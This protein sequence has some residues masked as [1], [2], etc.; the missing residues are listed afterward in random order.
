MSKKSK[1][2]RDN[3]VQAAAKAPQDY[4]PL[5]VLF[6]GIGTLYVFCMAIIFPLFVADQ[7]GNGI[8]AAI[9]RLK[10]S[11][12]FTV[13]TVI[14]ILIP[15]AVALNM[16]TRE[17]RVRWRNFGE[18]VNMLTLADVAVAL[19]WVFMIFSTILAED[20]WSVFVGRVN[21][22]DGALIQT[23]YVFAYFAISRMA[24]Y[25]HSTAH[26]F[27]IGGTATALIA[28]AHYFGWDLLGTGF[29]YPRWELAMNANKT[30]R[31]NHGINFLGSM[32]NINLLS[33]FLVIALVITCGMFVVNAVIGKKFDKYGYIT[34]ACI[35]V[36]SFAERCANTDAGIVALIAALLVAIPLLCTSVERVERMGAMLAAALGGW[37][38]NYGI[39]KCHLQ[40]EG[41]DSVFWLLTIGAVFCAVLCAM[42]H[43]I[44]DKL[45]FVTR[46]GLL[47]GSLSVI[48]LGI[49]GIVAV[50]LYASFNETKGTLYELGMIL[51][52][53]ISEKFGSKRILIWQRSL[54]M[55]NFEPISEEWGE[56]FGGALRTVL[57]PFFGTG[58]DTFLST[59]ETYYPDGDSLFAGKNL[60][61]AH[62]E[63][64]QILV[65]QGIFG[66][67]TFVAFLF[68]LIRDG[69]KYSKNNPACAAF[70]LAIIAYAFHAIFGYA[71]PV[72]TPAMWAMFGLAGSA[73]LAGRSGVEETER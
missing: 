53:N 55:V 23:C 44:G 18:Y 45:T 62:N 41:F 71:L 59:I 7:T 1:Q 70:V 46:K 21:R 4:Y 39:V 15:L 54:G 29:D 2:R 17:T 19:Y 31:E 34:L 57:R 25:R 24:R 69:V 49:I 51:R 3:H 37:A 42:L 67:G 56:G 36:M 28:I 50:A 33:Y 38:L 20:S 11:V 32:G 14:V 9:T 60:D 63:Y 64:L 10:G 26:L 12:F 22:N 68:G 40:G 73:I 52:G 66:L 6:N 65:C 47:I 30:F 48:G 5:D 8:Y 13:T 27:S 72:N 61:K 58:P 43:L 16:F 35:F